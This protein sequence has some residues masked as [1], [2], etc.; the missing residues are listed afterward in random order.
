MRTGSIQVCIDEQAYGVYERV[1]KVL[2]VVQRENPYGVFEP[3][4]LFKLNYNGQCY[5]IPTHYLRKATAEE[6]NQDKRNSHYW[7]NT[8]QRLNLTKITWE[9]RTRTVHPYINF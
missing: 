7:N 8:E 1:G 9:R 2:A 4:A 5:I 3:M 6:K